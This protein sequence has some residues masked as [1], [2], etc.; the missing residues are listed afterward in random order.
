MDL[1]NLEKNIEYIFKN[2]TFLKIALTHTSYANEKNVESNE[3]IEFLG[4]AILEYIISKHLFSYKEKIV[5][6]EMTKVRAATVCEKSLYEIAK[7]HNFGDFLFLG[8]SEILRRR[9]R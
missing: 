2:K 6:G 1:E 8:K 5:E 3:R 4:D 9:K 7:K